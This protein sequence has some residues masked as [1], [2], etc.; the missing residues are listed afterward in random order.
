MSKVT[1]SLHASEDA[2]LAALIAY[3]ETSTLSDY[4]Q[5][6]KSRLEEATINRRARPNKQTKSRTRIANKIGMMVDA[7]SPPVEIKHTANKFSRRAPNAEGVVLPHAT[8]RIEWVDL[9]SALYPLMLVIRS[10]LKSS[11]HS[12]ILFFTCE[13]RAMTVFKFAQTSGLGQD[14]YSRIFCAQRPMLVGWFESFFVRIMKWYGNR[15]IHLSKSRN[16]E[17]SRRPTFTECAGLAVT[18]TD[19][20]DTQVFYVMRKPAAVFDPIPVLAPLVDRFCGLNEKTQMEQ[21]FPPRILLKKSTILPQLYEYKYLTLLPL[22]EFEHRLEG[23]LRNEPRPSSAAASSSSSSSSRSSSSSS[24]SLPSASRDM[25]TTIDELT[26]ANI[27][28]TSLVNDINRRPDYPCTPSAWQAALT[29]ASKAKKKE[30]GDDATRTIDRD[31]ANQ[32]KTKADVA[33]YYLAAAKSCNNHAV[34]III[35]Y[36]LAAMLAEEPESNAMRKKG[37]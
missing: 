28:T 19:V 1:S 30:S 9:G 11:E 7:P 29:L 25:I 4:Q 13:A 37:S 18:Q 31:I 24:S 5:S 16:I 12:T 17:S 27:D 14:L 35:E 20:N 26:S 34:A 8:S 36:N 32:W 21:R 3:D 33:R 2:A 15:S 10:V 23:Q 22:K 6:L